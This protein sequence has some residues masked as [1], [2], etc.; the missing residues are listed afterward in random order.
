MASDLL[1]MT[2]M[3]LSGYKIAEIGLRSLLRLHISINLLIT[4][5]AVGAFAIGHLEEGAAVVFLFNIAEKLEDYAADRARRS[6]ESLM[7]LKP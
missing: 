7:E 5:A 3:I 6:I 1:L 2:T 4:I